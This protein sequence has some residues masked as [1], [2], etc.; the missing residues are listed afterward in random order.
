MMKTTSVLA[1]AVRGCR[2][3]AG[4]VVPAL[5]KVCS[6]HYSRWKKWGDVHY[7]LTGDNKGAT[8]SSKGCKNLPMRRGKCRKHYQE[9]LGKIYQQGQL[10]S[11]EKPCLI[12]GCGDFSHRRG[13]C[14]AH[15]TAI[16]RGKMEAPFV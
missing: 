13:Y 7:K 5:G 11:G 16:R 9:E 6:T 14:N 8:C 15:Y 3:P 10:N 1:C 12:A 4:S 2:H